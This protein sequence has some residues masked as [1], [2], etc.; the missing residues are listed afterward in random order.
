MDIRETF[1]G[2]SESIVFNDV[3]TLTRIMEETL[4]LDPNSDDVAFLKSDGR[5][6]VAYIISFAAA[7]AYRKNLTD[8]FTYYSL[9]RFFGQYFQSLSLHNICYQLY[10]QIQRLR[11]Q[12]FA[13]RRQR[14]CL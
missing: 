11:F 13:K 9:R 5:I 4:G 14:G 10:T 7:S 2:I 3:D 1:E 12:L 8:G 6:M